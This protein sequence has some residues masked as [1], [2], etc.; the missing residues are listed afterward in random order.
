MRKMERPEWIAG[1]E[2]RFLTF[3]RGLG[4]QDV[5]ALIS[6]KADLDGIVSAKVV[7]SVVELDHLLLLDYSDLGGDFVA[8]LEARGVTKVIISDM[9][10]KQRADVALLERFAHVMII[11]HHQ[12]AEDFNSEKTVFLNTQGMCAAYLCYY[13]FST[14]KDCQALAWAVACAS[15]SDW[16]WK[17]NQGW[18]ASVF[19]DY[20]EMF[21]G[22]DDGV[23][24]GAFWDLQYQ[25][26]LAL[27]Y[28]K[29]NVMEFYALFP[30]EFGQ[31]GSLSE[32]TAEVQAEVDRAL[33]AFDREQREIGG[34]AFWEFSG[35]FPVREL[36]INIRSHQNPGKTLVICERAGDIYKCSFRRQ[37]GGEDVSLLAKKLVEGFEN[38]DGG[39]HKPAAGCGLPAHRFAAFKERLTR[40]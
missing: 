12:F 5:I 17:N 3:A 8:Q 10:F 27:V 19:Q 25:L 36:V 6:H 32:H 33:E 39:G 37:D 29:K 34:R 31:L 7:S 16:A 35:K 26:Y 15:L 21:V 18:L 23:K 38:A 2:E 20:G 14:I 22:T 11:D 9:N 1:T 4:E 13:L 40:L 30:H 24:R 28:Y